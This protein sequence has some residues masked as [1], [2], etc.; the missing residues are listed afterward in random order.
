MGAPTPVVKVFWNGERGAVRWYAAWLSADE[1]TDSV[2]VDISALSPVPAAIKVRSISLTLN[3]DFQ[4]DIEFDATT[5]ELIDRFIGQ[6]D[7]TYQ[8][9]ED[10]TDYPNSG[11]NPDTS[12]TGFIGDLLVTTLGAASGDEL[13]IHLVFEKT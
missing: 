12:A 8:F 1:L 6:A 7:V 5:D 2:L 3:G 13:K 4:A 9:I 11:F 10:Y